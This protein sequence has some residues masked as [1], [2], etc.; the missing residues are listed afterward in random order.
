M[1][2]LVICAIV[3]LLVIAPL[4]STRFARSGQALA[5]GDTEYKIDLTRYFSSAAGEA[6]SRATVLADA[7]AFA[8]SATPLSAEALL[9]WLQRY[10]AILQ[11]LERHDIYVYLRAEEDD[12]D[13]ADAKADDRLG[14]AEDLISNRVT[15]AAR[16]L[17]AA[18]IARLTQQPALRP[19]RYLLTRSLAQVVH[20][21]TPSESR[22]VALAVTPVLDSAASTYKAL[23]KSK[24][25][26]E[27]DREAYAALLVSI[28]SARNG[29]AR[30]RGFGSAADASYFDK[31]SRPV[32][33]CAR[34]RRGSRFERVRALSCGRRERPKP[35]YTPPPITISDAIPL[36]L[37][38]EQPMGA[39]YAGAYM[40]L[41]DPSMHRFELCSAAECDDTGFSIGFSGLESGVFYGGYNGTTKTVRAVA[42]ESGHAVH[43][44]F[45][46]R[47]QP[48]AAYNRGPA[49]MFE[50]FA[51]FNELLFLDHLYRTAA[52]NAARAYYLK[53]FLDD[54][55]FQVYGSAEETE[56]ESA[57][58]RGV[59]C[60]ERRFLGIELSDER[61]LLENAAQVIDARTQ[62][63]AALYSSK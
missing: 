34:P 17:G 61:T 49:F 56:L 45:M 26:I 14:A 63:L 31:E 39:D 20:R 42:H 46:A 9:K 13:T 3:L 55:T 11:S 10:D 1:K 48:I 32:V 43:R 19:Y 53:Y 47:H 37:A 7:K 38:A 4:P 57:I 15:E 35:G 50:S 21:L 36:I 33:G 24:D 30:L 5:R 23:R 27:S 58:Y 8:A 12:R 62:V 41:L 28:A 18:H 25:T 60:L 22:S 52:D 40:Q 51:I 44:Q 54:A 6:Q 29:V 59:D 2:P 16:G